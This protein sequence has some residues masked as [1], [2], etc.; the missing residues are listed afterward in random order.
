[1][2][3]ERFEIAPRFRGPPRSGNGGYV[4][5]IV[6]THLKG[7]VAVRLKSPPPLDATLRLESTEEE[8]RLFHGDK[9]ISEAKLA[10][11][12]LQSPPAPSYEE[13]QLAARSFPGFETHNFPGCFVCGPEREPGDG[14]RIF[15][16][17]IEGTSTYAAPW[18]PDAT[19][20]DAH[21]R[22]KPEFLWSALDCPGA[23]VLMPLPDGVAIV[24]GELCASIVDTVRAHEPCVV[25]AWPLGREGRKRLAGSALHGADGRRIASARAVW[26]E[27]AASTWG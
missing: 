25:I 9:L 21:G 7:T 10:E 5:G 24:L 17:R 19:L 14:L 20:V 11:L 27:V 6:A 4:S 18:T 1:M 22:V 26:I 12:G 2:H 3:T 15:P 13:A 16:G 8:A 23:F